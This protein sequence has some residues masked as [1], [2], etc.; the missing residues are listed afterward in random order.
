MPFF[1]ALFTVRSKINIKQKIDSEKE[2]SVL[3]DQVYTAFI[4]ILIQQRRIFGFSIHKEALYCSIDIK[5]MR[6]YERK[7]RK[8]IMIQWCKIIANNLLYMQYNQLESTEITK[9]FNH[10]FNLPQVE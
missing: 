1:V 10:F 8:I 3:Q 7:S 4:D 2:I 6:M 5:S 9:E